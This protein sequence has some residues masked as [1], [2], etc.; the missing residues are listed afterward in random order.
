VDITPRPW[1]P[2][3]WSPVALAGSTFKQSTA[4]ERCSYHIEFWVS[5]GSLW[6]C[7]LLPG[8]SHS[9]SWTTRYFTPTLVVNVWTQYQ[10]WEKYEVH[11]NIWVVSPVKMGINPF[12]SKYEVHTKSQGISHDDTL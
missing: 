10:I 3:P 6:Y 9:S 1:G 8:I 7:T 2:A 5:Q 11:T 12:S 4:L